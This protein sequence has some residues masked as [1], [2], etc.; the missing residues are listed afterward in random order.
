MPGGSFNSAYLNADV[1][2]VVSRGAGSRVIDVDGK[3]YIDFV[4]G[5]GPMVLGHGHPK[6]VDALKRAVESPSNYYVLNEAGILLAEKLVDAIPCAEQIKYCVTGSEATFFAMRLARAYTGRS[7]VLKFEGGFIGTNDYALMSTTPRSEAHFPDP[8]PDSAG[9]PEALKGQVLVAPYN[10]LDRALEIIDANRQDL[11]AVIVEP[12]QRMIDPALGF[13]EGLRA[14]TRERGIVLIFDEVVTGFRLAYGGAQ[15][16]YGVTPDLAT[17][18]KII[19]GGLPLAAVAGRESIM[20][21]A[22]PRKSGSNESYV[23]MSGT[24]SGNAMAA[25]AGLAT[26]GVLREPGTYDKLNAIGERFRAGLADVARRNN[27]PAQVLGRG[28]MACIFF[29]E[30]PIV[31]YR[32]TLGGDAAFARKLSDALIRRGILARVEAKFYLSL[33]HSENDVDQTLN[34]IDESVRSLLSASS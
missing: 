11:A 15:A 34:V 29:T 28:P 27:L 4:L 9:I 24:L 8:V 14:A 17:Y 33:A 19:G 6:V 20:D 22:N 1:D 7:K 3:E 5:S 16:V 12:Q 10:D 23:F 13:L 18:G 2:V 26:L 32:S 21:L 31:D 25:A 30:K